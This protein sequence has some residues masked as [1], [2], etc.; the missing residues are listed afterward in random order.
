MVASMTDQLTSDTNSWIVETWSQEASLPQPEGTRQE[1]GGADGG[2]LSDRIVGM[3]A[4]VLRSSD[5]DAAARLLASRMQQ[6]LGC[7]Q[8]VIG[9]CARRGRRCR[10]R[11]LSDAAQFDS[12]S[13]FIVAIEDALEETLTL[14]S[15]IQ[16]PQCEQV[17][18][19]GVLAHEKLVATL[20]V[21]RVASAPLIAGAEELVGAVLF[22]DAST[23]DARDV[24]D[25]YGAALAS[26]LSIVERH[27]GSFVTRHLR[28]L[29][30]K[31][32]SRM[33]FMLLVVAVSFGVLL[34]S[35]WPYHVQCSCQI[36]PV[37]RRFVVAPYDGTLESASVS[38]GDVVRA[39][40]VLASMDE[41][42][43]RWELASLEAEYAS[44]KKERDAAMAGHRTAG[45]QLAKLE[46]KRLELQIKLL[47]HRV[48]NLAVRSPI[49][50][51]V[52]AGDLEKAQGAPLTIGQTLFEIAPLG[53]M[54]VEVNVPEE[55]V[56]RVAEGMEVTVRLDALSDETV[57]GVIERIHPQAELRD[58]ASVFVADFELAN[59]DGRLRPGMNGW[60]S[61]RGQERS[62]AWILF[63]KPWARF[64]RAL[65]W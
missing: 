40:D 1:I 51:V 18:Q 19:R 33:G 21:N 15:W 37:V 38:P 26:C 22:V 49:D 10:V 39:G 8:V 24:I 46:M 36:Q 9:I 56:S 43:I 60:A 17:E 55:D 41:R 52:V 35:P 29:R 54:N 44:A 5:A 57:C 59:S 50:G 32:R 31:L 53:K 6:V 11:G 16:W 4:Q 45:A 28:R 58:K 48:D 61:I 34:A 42:E 3:M 14:A 12:H 65:A 30:E 27:Q 63:H 23:Q 25:Q 64:R 13:Q 62:L 20:R 2:P 7:R 47:E